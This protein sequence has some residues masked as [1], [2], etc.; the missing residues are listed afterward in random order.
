[1]HREV[2]F[3]EVPIVIDGRVRDEWHDVNDL[4]AKQDLVLASGHLNMDEAVAVFQL[5]IERGVQRLL[6]NHPQMRFLDWRDEHVLRFR[7]LG[8]RVEIGVVADRLANTEPSPTE[9]FLARCP[10]ELLVFGS[11]LGH[12]MFSK[13]ASGIRSFVAE[14]EGKLD[15]SN[16]KP[17]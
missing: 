17:C 11:D 16:S 15:S 5:A 10:R 9:Y 13:Y 2:R 1:M 4:V 8:A 6:V 14:L 3:S 12:E 7:D